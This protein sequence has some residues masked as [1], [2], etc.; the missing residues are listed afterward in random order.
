MSTYDLQFL[1]LEKKVQQLYPVTEKI[2]TYTR[3]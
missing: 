2:T 3:L 1:H